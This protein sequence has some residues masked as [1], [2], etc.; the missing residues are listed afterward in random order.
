MRAIIPAICLFFVFPTIAMAQQQKQAPQ[1]QALT[2]KLLEEI[3]SNISL[4]A[5]VIQ[6]QDEVKQMKD[7]LAHPPKPDEPQK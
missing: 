7:S 5:Q 6:L 3:S 1:E 4:R 2:Q